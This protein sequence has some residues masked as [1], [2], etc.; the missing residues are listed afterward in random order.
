MAKEKPES[1]CCGGN[2]NNGAVASSG[3]VYGFGLFGALYFYLSTADSFVSGLLGVLK[4]FVWP[5][6]MVFH[7]FKFL[8]M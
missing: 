2:K 3:A 4:A 5:G 7:L 6:M 1:S 8:G